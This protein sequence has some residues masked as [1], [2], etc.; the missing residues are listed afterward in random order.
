MGNSNRFRKMYCIPSWVRLIAKFSMYILFS[1]LKYYYKS[2]TK[3]IDGKIDLFFSA[4]IL[5]FFL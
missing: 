2:I 1:P 3:K 5:F 4:P